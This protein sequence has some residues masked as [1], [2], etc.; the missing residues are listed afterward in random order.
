MT[1]QGHHGHGD[2]MQCMPL[3]ETHHN[4]VLTLF[5]DNIA[6][7]TGEQLEKL[8]KET[9]DMVRCAFGKQLL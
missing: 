1:N 7:F 9:G 3:P 6:N 8:K 2:D 5:V 4:L